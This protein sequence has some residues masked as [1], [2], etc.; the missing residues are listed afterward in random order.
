MCVDVDDKIFDFSLICPLLIFSKPAIDLK[1][2]VFPIPEGPNKQTISPL[3]LIFKDR[4]F[5]LVIP[6]T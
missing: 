2:V 6:P 1:I 5:I 3:F 4:F